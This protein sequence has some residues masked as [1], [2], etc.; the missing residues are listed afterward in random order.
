MNSRLFGQCTLLVAAL[1]AGVV[2][3]RAVADEPVLSRAGVPAD[4]TPVEGAFASFRTPDA[5]L[6]FADFQVAWPVRFG[7][8]VASPQRGVIQVLESVRRKPKGQWSQSGG[9]TDRSEQQAMRDQFVAGV[10]AA[11]DRNLITTVRPGGFVVRSEAAAEGET[12]PRN[13]TNS[14]TITMRFVSAREVAAQSSKT[15]SP[16][17]L[18][19]TSTWFTVFD[20]A[21][22]AN[23]RG[24][25][26]VMPGLLGTP[27]GTLVAL[28]RRLTDRGWT[29]LRMVA[30][31]SRFT[32]TLIATV[33]PSKPEEEAAT[34]AERSNNGVAEIAFAVQAAT[35]KLE[36]LRPHLAAKPRVILGSSAGALTL[37]TVVAREPDRYFASVIVGGGCHY[38]LMGITSNYNDWMG[39][40]DI[41]WTQEP[42]TQQLRTLEDAYLR[43]A[44]LD[45]YHTAKALHGKPVLILQATQDLAVPSPLG[46]TLLE[47][48]SAAESKPEREL[49]PGGH[50]ALFAA[51]PMQFPRILDWIDKHVPVK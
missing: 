4:G 15:D 45:S 44:S 10:P 39:L 16:K 22:V 17:S 11:K 51:L 20:A 32:Q 46:D 26:V 41:T 47:R 33:D 36:E 37:T 34:I 29:V 24:V 38:W 35:S 49:L 25:A 14:A 31:P 13:E 8:D 43:Q 30:Q 7:F 2:C 19:L 6:P 9:E 18:E 5:K 42:T 40:T 3:A 1:F 12:L 48:L 23:S 28:Q 50:E 27:E 21:D